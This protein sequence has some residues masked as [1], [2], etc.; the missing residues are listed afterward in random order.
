MIYDIT[1]VTVWNIENV[2]NREKYHV[3]LCFSLRFVHFIMVPVDRK[4]VTCL[5][6]MMQP[7]DI[8]QRDVES[9]LSCTRQQIHTYTHTYTVNRVRAY[10]TY[11]NVY[12]MI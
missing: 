3:S 8:M 6:R 7:P 9:Q 1:Y 4:R 11:T 10:V 2:E 12:G 5:P